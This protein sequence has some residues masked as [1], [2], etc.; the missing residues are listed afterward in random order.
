MNNNPPT[1]LGVF[2][3]FL[4]GRIRRRSVDDF[5]DAVR[6]G[7]RRQR[8]TVFCGGGCVFCLRVIGGFIWFYMVL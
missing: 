4:T 7:L 1:D 5:E 6:S 2:A 8:S 3:D